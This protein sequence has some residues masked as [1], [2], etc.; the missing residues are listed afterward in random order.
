MGVVGSICGFTLSQWIASYQ[1]SENLATTKAIEEINLARD[2][3]A[4]FTSGRDGASLFRR[5]RMA[6]ES[7][8]T[9]YDSNGGHFTN[10]DINQYL[11][12][13]DN[14]GYYYKKRVLDEDII[15]QMFGAYMVEAYK[16][17]ELTQYIDGMQHRAGQPNAM[18]EFQSL[19][20]V[21]EARP[22]QK[23]SAQKFETAC[24]RKGA[25]EVGVIL[26]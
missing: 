9:L 24:K 25:A 8:E 26:K 23:Q 13:F 6:I 1:F 16:S 10:D 15:D 7:C 14:I 2:L 11:N 20:K 5:I 12:F 17:E 3:N 22:D 18:A 21:L 19:A 4:E